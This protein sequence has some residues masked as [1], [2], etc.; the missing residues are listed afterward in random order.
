MSSLSFKV[1]HMFSGCTGLS[2][3][4]VYLSPVCILSVAGR[5]RNIQCDISADTRLSHWLAALGSKFKLGCLGRHS[6]P[7]STELHKHSQLN[8][9]LVSSVTVSALFPRALPGYFWNCEDSDSTCDFVSGVC[10]WPELNVWPSVSPDVC[11][12]WNKT[13]VLWMTQTHTHT[14][15]LIPSQSWGSQKKIL[16]DQWSASAGRQLVAVK[17]RPITRV[18]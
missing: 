2:Q 7:R 16:T 9:C 13:S 10:I 12:C 11:R 5:R 8:D 14:G 15:T 18:R 4:V 1:G 6:C 17:I 3:P